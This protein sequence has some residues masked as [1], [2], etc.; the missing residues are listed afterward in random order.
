[1][2]F[3][4]V[5]TW[6]LKYKIYSDQTGKFPVRSSAGYQYFMVM[7][8]IDS[9]YVLVQPIKNKTNREMIGSYEAVMK[10]LNRAGI[11]PEKHILDNKCSEKLKDLIRET[12]K[13]ELVPLGYHRGN[14]AKVSIKAFKQHFLSILAGLPD[15]F[16]WSLW[17]RLLPQTEVTLNLLRQSNT[18]PNVFAYAHMYGNFD[19]N[20]MPLAPIGCLCQVH[21]KPDN[22]K[23][24]NFHSQK[25]YYLFTS[26]KHYHTNNIFMKDTKVERLSDTVASQYPAVLA[27]SH[28]DRIVNTV[29]VLITLIEGMTKSI[30]KRAR[31][32]NGDAQRLASQRY[33]SAML[34]AALAV[35]DME[36]GK[37][38]KHRQLTTHI[39][40][41]IHRTWNTSIANKVGRLF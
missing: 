4:V 28:T 30:P 9:N 29:T 6:D 15:G 16:L 26:G 25:G 1:M 32:K 31:N 33:L 37:M 27:I 17:D 39:D 20:R 18:A 2:F 34:A 3:K 12:C 36:S 13:L 10:R 21:V 22:H 24:W 8:E 40:P 11:V 35:M 7:V 23:S 5:D 19:Y 41:L 38:T 14:I